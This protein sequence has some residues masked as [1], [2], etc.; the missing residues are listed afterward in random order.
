LF[1]SKSLSNSPTTAALNL[2]KANLNLSSLRHRKT[3]SSQVANFS[4]LTYYSFRYA[5]AEEDQKYR[6][7]EAWTRRRMGHSELSN[8][9]DQYAANKDNRVKFKDSTLPLGHDI[10]PARPTAPTIPLEMVPVSESGITHTPTWLEK[11]PPE[12]AATLTEAN[13]LA[14]AYLSAPSAETLSAL[15]DYFSEHHTDPTDILPPIGFD[16]TFKQTMVTDELMSIFNS[17][18]EKLSP[19]QNTSTTPIPT[20]IPEIW[21]MPQILY[22]NFQNLLE[23]S[24]EDEICDPEQEQEH[25]AENPE[26]EDPPENASEEEEE[27]DDESSDGLSWDDG[28]KLNQ[29]EPSNH[30]VIYCTNPRDK[31]ALQ[32]T[33]DTTDPPQTHYIWVAKCVNIQIRPNTDN[34]QAKISAY[35]YYNKEKDPSKPLSL[36]NKKETIIIEERSVIDVYTDTS[37]SNLDPDNISDIKTFLVEHW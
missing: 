9:K 28:F 29:I 15:T 5:A 7:S 33:I 17:S 30:I 25:S 37:L 23:T 13:D 10:Y 11:L 26:N 2:F 14:N 21:S 8:T 24:T 31:S 27:G 6:I 18:K 16:I 36:N 1:T 4:D 32:I 34:K 35:L 22:G 3:Q 20:R 12:H 19:T